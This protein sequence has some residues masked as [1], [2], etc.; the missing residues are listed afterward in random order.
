MARDSDA[1]GLG[2]TDSISS[3]E[4]DA[5]NGDKKKSKRPASMFGGRG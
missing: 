2:H 1:P 3:N 5:K 4:N